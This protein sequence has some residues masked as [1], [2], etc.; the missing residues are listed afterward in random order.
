[1]VPSPLG[2]TRI[3]SLGNGTST[4]TDF[5]TAIAGISMQPSE[6]PLV[7]ADVS[8]GWSVGLLVGVEVMRGV[9]LG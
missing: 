5:E 1:M 3:A 9:S 4:P 2:V 6:V 7:G 8:P